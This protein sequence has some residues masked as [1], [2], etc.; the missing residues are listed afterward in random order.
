MRRFLD[1]LYRAALILSAL[2]IVAIALMVL[3]QITGRLTDRA[4]L[5]LGLAPPGLRVPSIAEIGGFLFTGAVMLA[6]GPALK[7]GAHVRVT[8]LA[9]NLPPKAARALTLLVLIG[10]AALAI[11]AAWFSGLQAWDSWEFNSVSYGIVKVPLWLPQGAMA[12]GLALLAVALLDEAALEARGK[13]A[14]FRAHEQAE[15]HNEEPTA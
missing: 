3:T 9:G 2:A 6:L 4:A 7:A 11:W 13:L 8:M 1:L 14:G 15:R 5:A 12:F 10:A